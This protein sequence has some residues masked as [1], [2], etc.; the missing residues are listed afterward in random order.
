MQLH[1]DTSARFLDA[2]GRLCGIYHFDDPFKSF[3]GMLCTPGGKN[4]VSPPPRDHPHHK[5]LQ[6]GLCTADA[7]FW[8]ED[9]AHEPGGFKLPIGRQH[10]TG[11]TAL[12]PHAGVGFVQEIAWQAGKGILFHE[13]RTIT[14]EH[15]GN[16]YRCTWQTLLV[17]ARENTT[18]ITSLWP[19][20][21]GYCGLGLRLADDLFETGRVTPT[22]VG[23]GDDPVRVV[24]QG[25][26]AEVRFEQAPDQHHVLFVSTFAAPP[27]FAFMSM[28]PSNLKPVAVSPG[29][30]F[31]YRYVV[32]VADR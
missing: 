24:Y 11:L 22:G 5:G 32:D 25:A 2:D 15:A 8:E 30:R 21:I 10:T 13:T 18:I 19:G 26:G 12:P 23:S 27:Q 14:L 31:A 4:V 17:A 28:G 16:A 1:M 7:N 9:E 3:F 6:F 29:Q 20:T